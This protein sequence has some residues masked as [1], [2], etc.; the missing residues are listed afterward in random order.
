M[1]L[2][3][4]IGPIET[5]ISVEHLKDIIAERLRMYGFVHGSQIGEIIKIGEIKDGMLPF[6]YSP[7]KEYVEVERMVQV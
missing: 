5:Q 1:N 7:K 4:D 3:K 2:Q 6:T